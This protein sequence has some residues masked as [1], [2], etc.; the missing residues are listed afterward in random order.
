MIVTGGRSATSAEVINGVIALIK[1]SNPLMMRVSGNA[2][3]ARHRGHLV[4]SLYQ[5][6]IHFAQPIIFRQHLPNITGNWK[7]EEWQMRQLNVSSTCKKRPGGRAIPLDN[8]STLSTYF[9]NDLTSVK[10][11]DNLDF[12]GA[13]PHDSSSSLDEKWSFC[14]SFPFPCDSNHFC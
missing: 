6:S 4:S 11:S 13:L 14:F 8:C 9:L 1:P 12:L 7:G 3:S 5:R 2:L 10:T